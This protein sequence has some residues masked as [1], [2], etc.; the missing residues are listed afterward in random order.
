MNNSVVPVNIATNGYA[1]S[2]LQKTSATKKMQNRV[3]T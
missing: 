1:F 2:S 3:L